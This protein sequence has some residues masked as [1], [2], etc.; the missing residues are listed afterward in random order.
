MKNKSLFGSILGFCL[1]A[2]I[3]V[4]SFISCQVGLG[5]AVDVAAP[6]IT[7][8][9]PKTSAIIRDTFAITGTWSD[10][11]S[12]KSVEVELRNTGT[13][14]TYSNFEPV[15]TMVPD[16]KEY[17]GDW[18]VSIDP[19]TAKVPDGSY[20]ATVT[21]TDNGKHSTEI[22]RTFIIDNT[23]P[24]MVLS[25]PS[26]SKT[27]SDNLVESYGQYLTL[28]GQAAD[29][30]DIEKIVIN[31][32]SK[33]A[34]ETLLWTKEI[35]SVP[36]TISLDVAKFLDKDVYTKIYGDEKAGEKYYY[37]T[38]TAYDSAKRYPLAGQEKTD[39]ELGNAESSYILWADW[40]KFQSEY[41]TASGGTTKLKVPD[42]YAIK[43][44]TSA[45][46]TRSATETSLIEG[47]F[48]KAIP[49]GSF[50]LNPENSPTFSISGLELGT[51]TDVEN[52]R[53]LTVQLAKGLDGLS[54]LTDD[55][56]VYL[57]P[58]SIDENNNEVLGKKIYPQTSEFQ[59][60]GDG[61]FLTKILKEDCKDADGVT[62]TLEYGK[63]YIIGVDGKDIENNKIVPSFDGKQYYIKFKAKN[64]APSLTITTPSAT[65]L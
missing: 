13:D 27:D 26:S 3:P 56:K 42:L 38:I 35:T 7:I 64:V 25:R 21:I 31:F 11:G 60:K 1:F 36:P 49:C 4:V 16:T 50:K 32:Y 58:V 12:I 41:Q 24:V 30:N 14:K 33:D 54:L 48:E 63:T 15:L 44:G 19:V 20:E 45:S 17:K 47:L 5:E 53:A 61:Q 57:I 22:T 29:D 28:E 8:D 43:A 10:D 51:T 39:D 23:S 34:P 40:E 46:S 6:V 55:M 65:T 37:C 52:E 62:V 18:Y 2:L 59:K 9:T